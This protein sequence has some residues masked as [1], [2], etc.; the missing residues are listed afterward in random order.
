MKQ[1]TK[2]QALAFYENKLYAGLTKRQIA[3]FQLEQQRLCVPFEI[4]HE[5]MQEALG[6]PVYTHEFAF[7]DLL[8]K[9]LFGEKQAPTLEEIL[10]LIPAEKKTIIVLPNED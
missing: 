1:L 2:K 8:K 3:E 4:F 9:E 5:A 6:R 7:P 10:D